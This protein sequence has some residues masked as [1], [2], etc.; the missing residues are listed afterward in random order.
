MYQ[1]ILV[2]LDGSKLA[3]AVMPHLELLAEAGARDI[4]LATVTE[5][6]IA[7]AGPGQAT[8]RADGPIPHPVPVVKVPAAIGKKQLQGQRYL[9]RWARKLHAKGVTARTE[10]LLGPPAEEITACAE[11]LGAD[12]I[13]MATHG[14]SGPSRWAFGSVS[15]KVLR[16]SDTPVL[17][18]R[19]SSA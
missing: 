5:R 2:P 10:V 13:V 14:R 1:T 11:R 9:D 3:E 4:V 8:F 15:D 6:V 7:A 19:S 12:L 18:I 16:A 17:L